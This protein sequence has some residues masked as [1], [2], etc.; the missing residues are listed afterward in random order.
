[1]NSDA[2][3]SH[4]SRAGER[5]CLALA[6]SLALSRV[7]GYELP[8]VVDTPLGRLDPVV[9]VYVTE[10]LGEMMNGKQLIMLMTGTEYNDQV[11]AVFAKHGP[12]VM[13]IDFNQTES[14]SAIREVI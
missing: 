3:R 4:H 6:F 1:M 12:C 13:E 7:S 10:V 11:K 2:R 8:I 9:Q 14:T 5:E